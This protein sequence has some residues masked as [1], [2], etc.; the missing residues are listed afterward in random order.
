MAKFRFTLNI[1]LPIEQSEIVEID[2]DELEGLTD[3]AKDRYL[4]H[5]HREWASNFID[6]SW[7]EID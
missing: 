4:K 3:E 6:G 5:E 7:E 2:D 1:G